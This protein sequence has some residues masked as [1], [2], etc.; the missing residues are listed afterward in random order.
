MKL[1][2]FIPRVLAVAAGAALLTSCGGS[3][4]LLAAVSGETAQRAG[5]QS[6]TFA[7]TGKEQSFKVPAGVT[8]VAVVATAAGS[9][10]G[11]HYIGANGGLVTATIPVTPGETLA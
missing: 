9:P 6:Q 5:E 2:D 3:R 10:T 11:Y 4:Q 1:S 7:Y 8:R